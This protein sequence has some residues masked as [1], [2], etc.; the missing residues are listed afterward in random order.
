MDQIIVEERVTVSAEEYIRM[1]PG[2]RVSFRRRK[3][4]CAC[5]GQYIALACGDQRQYFKHASTE[6]DKECEARDRRNDSEGKAKEREPPKKHFIRQCEMTSGF[7]F[8]IGLPSLPSGVSNEV[9][10]C[11]LTL[12]P[13]GRSEKNFL[14]SDWLIEGETTWFNVG[15]D[16]A[17]YYFLR[18][19]PSCEAA[20]EHWGEKFFVVEKNESASD[21]E[22]E[23]QDFSQFLKDISTD[24]I[25]MPKVTVTDVF[26]REE[27]DGVYHELPFKSILC[28]R[29]EFDGWVLIN[30]N[31]VVIDKIRLKADKL[32]DVHGL[33]FGMEIKILQGFDCVRT[34]RYERLRQITDEKLF[35]KLECTGGRPVRISHAWGNVVARLS[36]Y[37]KVRG[38]L[39][40]SIRSGVVSEGAYKLFRAFL[41]NEEAYN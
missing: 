35:L 23:S 22:E 30:K 31:S 7:Y 40:R 37:P 19:T 34:L 9:R 28:L 13:E 29:A 5:C 24:E 14:I 32:L 27:A 39:Y 6:A 8:E 33:E 4:R 26:D 20:L 25:S 15:S 38:W 18:L 12:T 36:A 17:D 11:M 2:E 16:A 41:L 21:V 3:F 1:H 10:R